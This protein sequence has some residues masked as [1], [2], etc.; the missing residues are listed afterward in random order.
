MTMVG[1]SDK[2][3]G[4]KMPFNLKMNTRKATGL[5]NICYLQKYGEV[6]IENSCSDTIQKLT[7]LNRVGWMI[8]L[9]SVENIF[10]KKN[11]QRY[12]F[13]FQL[14]AKLFEFEP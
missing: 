2:G 13:N 14:F 1:L 10:K 11:S 6:L 12:L 7:K 3:H 4:K 5:T 8:N 9:C